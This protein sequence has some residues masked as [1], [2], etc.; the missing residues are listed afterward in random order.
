MPVLVHDR[1]LARANPSAITSR[2]EPGGRQR[3]RTPCPAQETETPQNLFWKRDGNVVCQVMHAAKSVV[4]PIVRSVVP[5]CQWQ[6]T[7]AT[8]SWRRG[9]RCRR[10]GTLHARA[11]GTG[12]GGARCSCSQAV[13]PLG[14][15]RAVRAE[16]P[17]H[18]SA[19]CARGQQL[20]PVQPLIHDPTPLQQLANPCGQLPRAPPSPSPPPPLP[21]LPHTSSLPK[22]SFRASCLR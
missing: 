5:S 17:A 9:G 10:P 2:D 13:A 19:A 6:G 7:R 14:A 3:H 11:G 12:L 4:P 20:T 21:S 15:V 16:R 1:S 18:V 22:K 8:R